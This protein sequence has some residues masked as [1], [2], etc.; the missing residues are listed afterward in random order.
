MGRLGSSAADHF[1]SFPRKRRVVRGKLDICELQLPRM[2][3]G[4]RLGGVDVGWFVDF[5][6]GLSGKEAT[7][8][9]FD[10]ADSCHGQTA[11]ACGDAQQQIGDHG[12]NHLETNT[13]F[14]TGEEFFEFEVLLEPAKEEF[15]RAL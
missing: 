3:E 4:S 13:V 1:R 14:E 12:R 15:Q 7:G 9:E 2:S 10:K 6:D 8:N 5:G 11:F